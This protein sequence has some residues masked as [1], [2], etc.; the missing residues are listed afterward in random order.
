MRLDKE[1]LPRDIT[2]DRRLL[3]GP[4]PYREIQDHCFSRSQYASPCCQSLH[5][6][7][8]GDGAQPYG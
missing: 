5:P 3:T 1:P 4:L 7:V 8:D 6:A 2:A